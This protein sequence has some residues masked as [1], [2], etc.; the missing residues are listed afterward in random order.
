MLTFRG[1]F[2]SFGDLAWI[3]LAWYIFIGPGLS[4]SWFVCDTGEV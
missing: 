4:V 1:S 3:S 2:V